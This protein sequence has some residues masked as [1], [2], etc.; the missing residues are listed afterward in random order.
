MAVSFGDVA[1]KGISAA[2][3]MAAVHSSVRT[4][5]AMLTGDVDAA[6][7]REASARLVTETNRQLCAGTA[8]DKFATLFF[9]AYDERQ[10][11]LAYVNAG[12]LPPVLVRRRRAHR[13]DVTGMVVGAF[14]DARYEASAVA[15]EPGDLLVAFTDGLTEP[16]N[17]YG[18]QFGE[19]R[20]IEAL[21]RVGELPLEEIVQVVIGEI[22]AWTGQAPEQQDDMTILVARRLG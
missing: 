19:E 16:E 13:L 14:P 12:H 8:P 15:L 21:V 17:P 22:D 9:G 7:L 3:V 18:E 5:L 1:G 6:D 11:A 10:G 20:L 4:Q 2:L